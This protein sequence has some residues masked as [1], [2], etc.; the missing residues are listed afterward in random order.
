MLA[1]GSV[2][3]YPLS[4]AD[5]FFVSAARTAVNDEGQLVIYIVSN[6]SN[7]SKVISYSDLL[8]KSRQQGAE[9]TESTSTSESQPTLECNILVY[10]CESYFDGIY[11]KKTN[12]SKNN[13]ISPPGPFWLK[14]VQGS[15][16]KQE[17]TCPMNCQTAASAL[18]RELK[19]FSG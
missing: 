12:E 5:I 17:A 7:T 13:H 15:P 6:M 8:H 9:K 14:I 11:V 1:Q 3:I 16:Q 18:Q 2:D 4:A 10:K 19:I